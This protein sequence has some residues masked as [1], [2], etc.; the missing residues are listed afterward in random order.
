MPSIKVRHLL[1]AGLL[2]F[3]FGVFAAS[4][5]ANTAKQLANQV[6]ALD[7]AGQPVTDAQNNLANYVHSH[8]NASI[9]LFLAASFDRAGATGVVTSDG[10]VYHDAQ[11]A[12]TA[13]TS[14]V[15][16][17]KCVQDYVAA[18]STAGSAT[19]TTPT[20]DKSAYTTTYTSPNW[21]PDFAGIMFMLSALGFGLAAILGFAQRQGNKHTT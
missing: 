6:L 14:A 13:H 11:A 21:T 10:Q 5:N 1:I 7:N 3:I 12:C 2:A 16:Q 17:A 18:H 4:Q 19:I 8:M 15:N 9:K 20:P